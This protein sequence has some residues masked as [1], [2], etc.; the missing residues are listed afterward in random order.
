MI[1]RI[2]PFVFET[3]SSLTNALILFDKDSYNRWC[4]DTDLYINIW[5]E[6][7]KVYT[8]EEATASILGCDTELVD[9][10]NCLSERE[11]RFEGFR[12]ADN[13]CEDYEVETLDLEEEIGQ[14]YI[15]L[16]ACKED[17]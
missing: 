13:L 8:K 7:S 3:N 6:S 12:N 16:S 11:L 4:E 17:R 5:E 2:R 10:N 9:K 14:R 15:V 1:D